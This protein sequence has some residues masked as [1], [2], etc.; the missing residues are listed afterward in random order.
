MSNEHSKPDVRRE[1]RQID[2][3]FGSAARA[4]DVGELPARI[5]ND[6]DVHAQELEKIFAKN[7]IFVG[8]ETEIP[9]PGDFALRYM[10]E[11]QYILVRD[12]S[13]VIRVL[14]NNCPHRGTVIC[15]SDRGNATHFQCPYHSWAFKNSGEWSG[16]PLKRR[17]YQ[18]LNPEKAAMKSVPRVETVHGLIFACLDPDVQPLDQYLGGMRWYLDTIFGLDRGG[19]T[20]IGEPQKW[21]VK[22]NWKLAAE[23]FMADGYHVPTLHRSAEEVGMFPGID[24]AGAAGTSRHLYFDEGHG[25]LINEGF[26]PSPPWHTTGFPVGLTDTFD[27]SLLSDEQNDFAD[28]FALT[29]GTIFPNF[30]IV[31]VPAS[32]HPDAEPVVFT[33]L[34]L[35]QPC[36]PDAIINWNWTLGWN[37][38]SE[39][40]NNDAYIAGIA[41][42]GPAG[43]LEQDDSII[44]EGATYAGKSALAHQDK[45]NLN[46]QL[47][48][49]GMSDYGIDQ[50]WQWPGH[51]T[52][53]VLGETPQRTFYRR[54]LADMTSY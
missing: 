19:M 54:W 33:Y 12:D 8:H 41:M 34:R 6:Q 21:K 46:Y 15:R 42:H 36:G 38:A 5:F 3:L 28:R 50:D 47:G 49:D 11:D 26:L 25:M 37:A 40:F 22:A 35:W 52:T 53:T 24:A 32:P 20:V 30:G 17:A 31:R 9:A 51:A 48:T 7:W 10:G 14:L 13:G 18:A 1:R 43:I 44:W 2:Y 39:E 45:L 16:A 23:N 27:R 4:L 29:A